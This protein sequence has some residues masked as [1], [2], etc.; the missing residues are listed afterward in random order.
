LHSQ[1]FD[2]LACQLGSRQAE[3]LAK[4]KQD[5][6]E[7]GKAMSPG[8]VVAALTFGYWTAFFGT[9][10][11]DTWRKT[12]RGIARHTEGRALR[13]KDF[14]AALTPIRCQHRNIVDIPRRG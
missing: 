8:G 9:D 13:R 6:T 14:A 3:Q 7:E 11:E 2:E 4:A 1:W 12:L 5:L 10:Y